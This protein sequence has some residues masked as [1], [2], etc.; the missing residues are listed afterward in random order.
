[1]REILEMSLAAKILVVDDV[2]ANVVLLESLLRQQG[3]RNVQSTT[4]ARQVAALHAEKDFDLILLD[5]QMP[6]MDGFAVMEALSARAPGD[7]LPVIVVTAFSD[8]HNRLRALKQGARDFI[9]KPFVM[10]TDGFHGDPEVG[11]V[12]TT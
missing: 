1:M 5:L 9:L 4:D 12:E 6:H 10:E 11:R 8:Q 3:Y 7:F 2:E